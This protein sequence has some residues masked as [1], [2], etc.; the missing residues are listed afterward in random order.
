[1][2]ASTL[3]VDISHAIKYKCIALQG[4]T[5][6]AAARVH[7]SLCLIIAA[8]LP[9]H[10]FNSALCTECR[11]QADCSVLHPVPCR[12]VTDA[13]KGLLETIESDLAKIAA[14]REQASGHPLAQKLIDM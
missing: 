9:T 3:Q 7:C 4:V 2:F 8:L 5:A 1:M 13:E 12:A 10:T 11:R 6:A 14:Q